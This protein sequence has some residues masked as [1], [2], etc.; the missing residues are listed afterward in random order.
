MPN[1]FLSLGM[2]LKIQLLVMQV[3]NLLYG[4]VT[5]CTR[6]IFTKSGI[7]ISAGNPYFVPHITRPFDTP[8]KGKS[9]SPEHPLIGVERILSLASSIKQEMPKDMVI[10]GSGY[11]YLRQYAGHV[12]AGLVEKNKVDICGFGRMAFA[13]PDF[14]RQILQD[15][16]VNKKFT[17][18]SCSKCSQFM[19]DGKNTGCAIR[20]PEYK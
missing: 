7:T 4:M 3:I 10:I 8:I 19:R 2:L 12:A 11:S 9:L 6:G 5:S 16:G 20:D 1:P 15:G 17:C 13:N 18:I 14:P